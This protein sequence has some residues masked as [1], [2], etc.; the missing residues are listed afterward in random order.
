MKDKTE[1]IKKRIERHLTTEAK[2]LTE[3]YEMYENGELTIDDAKE[4]KEYIDKVV[5]KLV[6]KYPIYAEALK[7]SYYALETLKKALEQ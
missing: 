2:M 7:H 3:I 1:K 4:I 6:E 5:K